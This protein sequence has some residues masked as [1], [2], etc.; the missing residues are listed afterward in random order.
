MQGLIKVQFGALLI[1]QCQ[2]CV[3]DI[4]ELQN[5]SPIEIRAR[6]KLLEA[7]FKEFKLSKRNMH[8]TAELSSAAIYKKS[9]E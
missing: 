3:G 7:M 2:V 9:Q 5:E 4:L 6:D 1:L 8:K